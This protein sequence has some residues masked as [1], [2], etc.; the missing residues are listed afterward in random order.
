MTVTEENTK[1]LEKIYEENLLFWDTAWTRVTKIHKD[2]PKLPYIHEVARKFKKFQVK[3]VLDLACGSGWLSVFLSK[4]N[5][6]VT[7]IDISPAAIT[8]ANR[9]KEE[10]KIENV[11]FMEADIFNLP[12]PEKSFDAIIFNSSLEHFRADQAKIIFEKLSTILN[13]K[14]FLFGCFDKVG[15]GKGDYFELEDH[16]HV[17][18][19]EMRK[20]MMLRNFSDEELKN[21]L[22][23]F[24]ILSFDKNTYESR[25]VWARKK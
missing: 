4:Y 7:G 12:F 20:G 16:T 25:L 6:D 18:T 1:D 24:D 15:S 8:L 21:L 14:G 13:D 2:P 23:G 5:F 9:W 11:T 22:S 3:K 19:D 17:Y 10:D